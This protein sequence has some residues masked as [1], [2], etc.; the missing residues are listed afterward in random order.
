MEAGR[1]EVDGEAHL[2]RSRGPL[3]EGSPLPLFGLRVGR[4][5]AVDT[6]PEGVRFAYAVEPGRPPRSRVF[7]ELRDVTRTALPAR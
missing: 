7:A 6:G 5:L 2:V 4:L 3:R 1:I